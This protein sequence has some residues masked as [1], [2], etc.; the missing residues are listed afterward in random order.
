MKRYALVGAS[1][2]ALS[3]FA[4]PMIERY[5]DQARFVGIYDV[6]SVRSKVVSE[7]CGGIPV[8]DDFDEMLRRSRP[9]AVIVATV[10]RYHHEYIIRALEA[11]CTAIT[12]KPMT[13]DAEKCRAILAAE[14][15]T[16]QQVIVTFNGRFRPYDVRAKKLLRQGAIGQVLSVDLEWALDRRHGADYFRRWHRRKENSGGLLVHKGSHHFDMVNW[17]LDREPRQVYAHGTRRFYG[18]T[19]AE[20]GERCSTCSYAST[21]EFHVDYAT[22][23]L[24]K[25]LYFD[26]EHEDGYYR[27]ACVFSDEIDIEDTMSLTVKYADDVL[28]TYSLVAY[29]PYEAWRATISGTNGRMELQEYESGPLAGGSAQSIRV[30][31]PRGDVTTY[32]VPKGDGG[33]GG[34]D[35]RLQERLFGAHSLP[36]PL[37]QMASSWAGAMSMLIGVAANR[38]MATAQ[39]VAIDDLVNGYPAGFISSV[40]MEA[41]VVSDAIPDIRGILPIVYTPFD[42]DGRID[43]EDLERLVE[44][45]IAA[46]VHGLAAVGGASECHKMPVTERMWLAERTLHYARGRVPVIV[47]TSATNTAE[48]VELSR[49]AQRIGAGAVYVTPPLFGGVTLETLAHHFGAVARAISLPVMV[50]DALIS[51]SPSQIAELAARFPNVCY[52]KEEALQTSGHRISELKRLS[53]AVKVLSG[54]SYLLDDLARGAQGAIPGSVGVADLCLAFERFVAGDHDGARAAYD[55]FTPLSFWRRQA[56]LLGAKEVLKRIGVFKAAHLREPADQYLDDQDHRELTAI[57]ERM[58]PPY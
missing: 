54:G 15:R 33:H 31:G 10:D 28:L 25:A 5:R 2:R 52:A 11:G 34:G 39:C 26:A 20:R 47:G 21:C 7:Q 44:H 48:S 27:D 6:N 30:Y 1:N 56:P 50:Q 8:F 32:D 37:D 45:L 43:E 40:H 14:R 3:M 12:E 53:P 58:G 16:G 29:S 46:G 9:D 36:D 51:V 24:K 17:L 49:H 22:D 38:S 23:A 13:I 35:A 42:A 41:V 55:H 19:R 4:K 57:L 18:P